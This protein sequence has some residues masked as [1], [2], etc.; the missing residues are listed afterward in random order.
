MRERERET[1][2]SLSRMSVIGRGC[3][4]HHHHPHRL[5][6][7]IITVCPSSTPYT[8]C[9]LVSSLSL[10]RRAFFCHI[11]GVLHKLHSCPRFHEVIVLVRTWT[12]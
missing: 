3:Q 1:D 4:L 5:T 6:L 11:T 12:S 8:S 2:I 7:I 9:C 10:S